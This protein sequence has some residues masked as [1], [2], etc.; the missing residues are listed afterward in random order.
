M[1]KTQE[2]DPELAHLLGMILDLVRRKAEDGAKLEEIGKPLGLS[3][4]AIGNWKLRGK[5]PPYM[6]CAAAR[7]VGLRVGFVTT[8]A[9]T[10]RLQSAAARLESHE[11][12]HLAALADRLA[13]GDLEGVVKATAKLLNAAP[14]DVRSRAHQA[15]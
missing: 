2:P 7:L 12:D 6:L 4:A 11:V 9:A 8:D 3:K 13:A 15:K 10:D 14:D 1:G 5:I